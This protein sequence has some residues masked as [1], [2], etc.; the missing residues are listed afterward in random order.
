LIDKREARLLAQSEGVPAL[1][2]VGMLELQGRG[3]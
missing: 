2:T 3:F 1:G